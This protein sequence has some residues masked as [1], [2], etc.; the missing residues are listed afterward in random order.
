VFGKLTGLARCA[1]GK[2]ERSVER[3]RRIG[4]SEQFESV[5]QHCG[6]RMVRLAKRNWIVQPR[7]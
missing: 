3:A 4:N 5:C 1:V 2:H 6:V 7:R